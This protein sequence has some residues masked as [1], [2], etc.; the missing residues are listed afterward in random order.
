VFPGTVS[1]CTNPDEIHPNSSQDVGSPPHV[2]PPRPPLTVRPIERH[3]IG[4]IRRDHTCRTMTS[5][6]PIAAR[7]LRAGIPAPI[8][9]NMAKIPRLTGADQF[10]APG[11]PHTA[12]RHQRRPPLPKRLVGM[13]VTAQ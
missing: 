10:A 3:P 6:G 2:P 12:R 13:A 4:A 1:F 11:A 7:V 8:A 9:V 5:R